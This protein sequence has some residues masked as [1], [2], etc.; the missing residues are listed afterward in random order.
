MLLI[1]AG[2]TRTKWAL[3]EGSNW[4]RQEAVVNARLGDLPRVFAGLPV[5]RQVVI[6]NVAGAEVEQR[7]RAACAHW[8]CPVRL[9]AAVASQCGV[10]NGYDQPGQLG[11]DRWAALVAAWH[12]AGGACLVVN[13]GTATTVDALSPQGEFVGGLILPGLDLMRHSLAAGT[14]GLE[15]GAGT[16]VPFPR[17]TADAIC[18]GALQATAGAVRQQYEALGNDGAPVLL[19]GG[20]GVELRPLLTFPATVVDNL[21]LQGLFL[22]GQETGA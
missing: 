15:A 19:T 16:F 11:S 9:I 12:R 14:A 18:S 5:P 7:L 21:V 13:C 3:V 8:S 2:N 1:D 4:L 22:I 10:R 6:S 20:R 17:N